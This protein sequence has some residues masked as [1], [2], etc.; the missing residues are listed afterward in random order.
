MACLGVLMA[1]FGLLMACF[2]ILDTVIYLGDEY[3]RS[4]SRIS[5]MITSRAVSLARA[6]LCWSRAFPRL[7]WS[8]RETTRL[9]GIVA[10]RR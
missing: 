8:W 7:P 6:V 10:W 3:T 2:R 9:S 5:C 4:C 1:C